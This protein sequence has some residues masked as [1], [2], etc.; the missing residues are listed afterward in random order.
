MQ[1]DGKT[2]SMVEKLEEIKVEYPDVTI[3]TNFGYKHEDE[4]LTIG[5]KSWKNESCR[6]RFCH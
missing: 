6:D 3:I 4:A 1:G 2:I 5:F